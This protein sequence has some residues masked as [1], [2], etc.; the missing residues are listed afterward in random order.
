MVV[1]TAEPFSMSFKAACCSSH[2]TANISPFKMCR[3]RCV[4]FSL[5]RVN[6]SSKMSE[7]EC[8]NP[9]LT[10]RGSAA[11]YVR[12]LSTPTI[13]ESPLLT[14]SQE[15]LLSGQPPENCLFPGQ[16]S[17]NYLF[18]VPIWAPHGAKRSSSQQVRESRE[19]MQN[20]LSQVHSLLLRLL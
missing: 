8:P 5:G 9:T 14:S 4:N 18:R 3:T 19:E 11:P 12:L 1:I 13:R 6:G 7:S 20:K 2:M 17:V 10:S 16:P 15:W